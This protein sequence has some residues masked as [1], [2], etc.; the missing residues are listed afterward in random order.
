MPRPAVLDDLRR[1][2]VL[3]HEKREIADTETITTQTVHNNKP[4]KSARQLYPKPNAFRRFF[5]RWTIRRGLKEGWGEGVPGADDLEKAANM[6]RFASRPSDLFLKI[7]GDVLTT[8]DRNPLAGCVSPPLIGTSGT[9][10][11]TILST[12]P[13]IMHHYY[14]CILAAEHEV[15]LVTNYW[16][17]SNSQETICKALRDLSKKLDGS[18]RKIVVK[19][20]YDRGDI[21]QVLN[22]HAR[23]TEKK[24]VKLNIPKRSEIPNLE[25]EV[26]NYHRWLM[27]TL[28]AKFLI[29]DRKLALLNSNNIQDRPNLEFMVHLEGAVVNSFYDTFLI[30]WHRTLNP[31]LPQMTSPAPSD[32]VFGETLYF[33]KAS[34]EHVKEKFKEAATRARTRLNRDNTR[35]SMEAVHLDFQNQNQ[36]LGR[37]KDMVGRSS[38]DVSRRMER[39][40]HGEPITFERH[41]Q[42]E[43]HGHVLKGKTSVDSGI[44]TDGVRVAPHMDTLEEERSVVGSSTEVMSDVTAIDGPSSSYMQSEKVA[45]PVSMSQGQ[46]GLPPTQPPTVPN[47][48]NVSRRNSRIGFATLVQMVTERRNKELA[49]EDHPSPIEAFRAKLENLAKH[50]NSTGVKSECA[51]TL[52]SEVHASIL[53]DDFT[54]YIAHQKHVPIPIAMVS[55]NPHGTPGHADIRNP[56]DAAWMAAMRYAKREI[57]IQTPTFNAK[58]AQRGVLEACRRGIKCTL[59]LGLGFNDKSESFPFQGGTNEQVVR[60]LYRKLNKEGNGHEKNLVVCW[61]TGKDQTKPLNAVHKQ[62]NCHV[63]FMCVDNQVAIFGNGNMDTQ[64]WFHSQEINIM[65]D[66]ERIVQEWMV[67]FRKNQNTHL[68]G[69]TDTNGD[70][71]P[72]KR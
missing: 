59:W 12:I 69:Q 72:D 10:P 1:E 48:A 24:W 43:P 51:P 4:G 60:K 65:I 14:E 45:S 27:G 13:D 42:I 17:Q 30:T 31:S 29:V 53:D 8:L 37:F 56:Q 11:L 50:F 20:M 63:K 46:K 6:G 70:L 49:G 39:D 41:G 15:I 68:Y 5:L 66:D 9:L 64:S 26:I 18:R 44:L 22:F 33:S 35:A 47:S 3:R 61:Y 52:E 28:H 71:P 23:V 58:P 38:L 62:R 25:F 7:Y 21:S 19:L 2:S 16:Q 55:R 54:P 34:T 32:P 36:L 40:E 57:F 67:A